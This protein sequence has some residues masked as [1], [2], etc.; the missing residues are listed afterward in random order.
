MLASSPYSHFKG[1]LTGYSNLNCFAQEL[2]LATGHCF[3]T[4]IAGKSA[5]ELIHPYHEEYSTMTDRSWRID[6]LASMP[7]GSYKSEV[8]VLHGL[9]ELTQCDEG[10]LPRVAA[11]L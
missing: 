10:S 9:P 11:G 1:L 4:S 8:W 7:L 2:F 3:A 5:W 6:I